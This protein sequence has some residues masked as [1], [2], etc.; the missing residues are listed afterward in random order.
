[1]NFISSHRSHLNV[2]KSS[3]PK[4]CSLETEGPCSLFLIHC[5]FLITD[6]D[7]CGDWGYCDQQC[8]NSV[9]SYKCS[10]VDGYIRRDNTCVADPS[11]SKMTLLFAYHNKLVA[12]D[13]TGKTVKQLTNASDASGV[14]FHLSKEFI[15]FTDT[16]R[17]KV[18][19]LRMPKEQ[20]LLSS[21]SDSIDIHPLIDIGGNTGAWSPSAIAVD[22]IGD[23]LYVV[24][25][26]GQKVNVFD[27]E[28]KRK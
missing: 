7:E 13:P 12:M 23:N 28:G 16:E 27:I 10:C 5:F 26:L 1:M 14:D 21:A 20:E 24:D 19:K 9:G 25:S 15:F 8:S 3:L 4:C 11:L 2:R 18:Y 17:R 22:W 6:Q